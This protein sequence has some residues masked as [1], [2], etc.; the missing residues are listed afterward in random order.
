MEHQK[1]QI[2]SLECHLNNIQI[3]F[4]LELLEYQKPKIFNMDKIL[5]FLQDSLT[6][7]KHLT[8]DSYHSQE[9]YQLCLRSISSSHLCSFN[10]LYKDPQSY[11][12]LIKF[13]LKDLSTWWI[14]TN[15][16]KIN[17]LMGSSKI[18]KDLL[19][20][21]QIRSIK[22]EIRFKEHNKIWRMQR[23][24]NKE[25]VG[26]TKKIKNVWNLQKMGVAC[27]TRK[28]EQVKIWQVKNKIIQSW[29]N[30]SLLNRLEEM[31]MISIS[32]MSGRTIMYLFS[33]SWIKISCNNLF[34][35]KPQG[36]NI[37]LVLFLR[38][39]LLK[40]TKTTFSLC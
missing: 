38:I 5:F 1:K 30:N 34:L 40:W 29:T 37:L 35:I 25:K 15:L 4:T 6:C 2:Q 10:S 26:R 22:K 27:N 20:S 32:Q 13:L 11:R 39:K 24:K 33:R 14:S 7:N 17:F 28:F 9:V 31:K 12:D 3:K 16:N 21:M 18:I 19:L 8:K 36:L 23:V